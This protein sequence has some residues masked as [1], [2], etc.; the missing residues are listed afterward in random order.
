MVPTDGAAVGLGTGAWPANWITCRGQRVWPG[1]PT[2]MQEHHRAQ[3]L[4]TE[5]PLFLAC[6]RPRSLNLS[7]CQCRCCFLGVGPHTSRGS[8]SLASHS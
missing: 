4:C 6:S 3:G 5:S 7:V 2:I 8:L 1:A